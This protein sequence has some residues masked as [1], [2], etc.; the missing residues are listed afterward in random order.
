MLA[1]GLAAALAGL[2]RVRSQP[3]CAP[4][5]SAARARWTP[6]WLP[7]RRFSAAEGGRRQLAE[8]GIRLPQSALRR[9]HCTA[10]V[11]Q[12]QRG[13]RLRR[14]PRRRA[15]RRG[16]PDHAGHRAARVDG[17]GADQGRRHA[18]AGRGRTGVDQHDHRRVLRRRA[19]ADRHRRPG[20]VADDRRH[21]PGG[22]RRSADRR[23][24]RDA[25]RAVHRHPGQE[26]AERPVVRGRA[27][28][29]ATRR[30]WCWRR[31]RS[32]T[33]SPPRSGRCTWPRRC[34]RRRSCC[35][36]SSW[37]S[38]ARSSTGRPTP[39][40]TAERLTAAADTPD[41][42]RYRNT[43]SG[44]SPMAIPGTPGV[45][46]TADG[47]EHTE[48]GTPSSESRD[49]RLQLDKRE[50]KLASRLR[51]DAGPTSKATATPRSSPSARPP[52][53]C[54]RRSRAPR[55]RGSHV[56][57]GRHAAAG[58]GAARARSTRRSRACGRAGRRAEP[59]RAV[60]SLPARALRPA[61]Q[62]ASFHRP[63]PLPMRPAKWRTALL[64]WRSAP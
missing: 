26:R 19:L 12:R 41:Y 40:F 53:R 45:A 29:T 17:A 46:Y 3:P 37:A 31:T 36:T 13:G 50:R 28:C 61:R 33:A 38:R 15:L 22:H 20:P 32:P 48:G 9:G 39:A 35:R 27:G 62:A 60:L 34:R 64:E 23:R 42:K 58:A 21:R 54:A 51:P 7:S 43:D 47:L 52:A 63:G 10:L 56:A 1:L 5:G 30:A 16:L 2:P 11:D 59:W 24:R 49:H 57:P 55:R 6:T 14:D 4:P 44:V 25:R 18:A 8:A